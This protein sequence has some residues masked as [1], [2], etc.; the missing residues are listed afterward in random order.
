MFAN[1]LR[2][3]SGGSELVHSFLSARLPSTERTT[4]YLL[5]SALSATF[6]VGSWSNSAETNDSTQPI[7]GLRQA[8]PEQATMTRS[9]AAPGSVVRVNNFDLIRLAAAAQ[10]ALSHGGE[11]LHVQLWGPMMSVLAVLPGVPIFFVI[12]GFLISLSW[13][14]SPSVLNY[15]RNRVLRIYPALWVCLVVSIAIF[16]SAGVRPDPPYFAAWIVAQTTI[17]QFYNP[18]FLRHFGV[19]V[20]NGSLWTIPVELQFYVLLPFLALMA[21]K[22]PSRWIVLTIA[23]AVLMEFGRIEMIAHETLVQKL[24][25]VSVF[26]YLFYF[27]IGI[28]IRYL[29]EHWPSIFVGRAL[30]WAIVYAV[31]VAIELHFSLTGAHGNLLN[32]PSIVLLGMLTVSAAFTARNLSSRLLRGNDTSYGLY[33]YH[34]PI[35][36]LLIANRIGGA[37]GFILFFVATGCAAI[38]S[39][40]FVEAPALALKTYSV[41]PLA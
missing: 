17:G 33:I 19:G 35:L 13:E 41:R 40:R 4:D 30:A 34:M 2:A 26:P 24:I 12:S 39:W 29:Y 25:S 20:L 7:A 6:A 3:G 32:I 11:F 23:A 10:V 14:R 16:L 31:W 18:A 1:R 22:R 8:V 9:D 15:A 36:N 38:L 5:A 27:L 21:Q 37:S 28:S